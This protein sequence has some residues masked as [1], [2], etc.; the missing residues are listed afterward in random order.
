LLGAS[1]DAAALLLLK[2]KANASAADH[3]GLTPLHLAA[4]SA[5]KDVILALLSAG[6]CA[7]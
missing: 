4:A 6:A 3:S 1:G 2:A 5:S 7:R